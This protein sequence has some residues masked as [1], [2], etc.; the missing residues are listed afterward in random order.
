MLECGKWWWRGRYMAMEVNATRRGLI[1]WS[2][3]KFKAR[4]LEL[5]W[6][7]SH[8]GNL[9]RQWEENKEEI[10]EVTAI[11]NRLEAQEESY[12]ATRSRIQ[13]LQAGDSNTAFFHQSTIQRRRRNKLARIRNEEGGWQ[14]DPARVRLTVEDHFQRLFT[15]NGN[16]DWGDILY[17]L[18]SVVTNDM[19]EPLCSPISDEEIKDVVFNMGGSKAPRPDG[20]HGLFFQSYWDIIATEVHGIVID[21]LRGDGCPSVINSTNI[22]LILKVPNPEGVNH[23]RPISLCNYSY[24]VLSKILANRLKP[25]LDQIISLNQ[26]AF[27]KGRQIQENIILAHENFHFLKMR[28][29]KTKFEM[30]IK[31]DMNKAYDRVE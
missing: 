31:L 5:Q 27:I 24:K 11:I 6:L 7:N 1:S 28:R 29:T 19:N 30:R 10:S 12:W 21:C 3:G 26:N 14:E 22:A 2:S 13:W 15:S 4:K 20:F 25:L 8:L 17:C 18:D 23:F 9:Q 16:R